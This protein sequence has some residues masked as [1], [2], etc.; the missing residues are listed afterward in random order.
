MQDFKKISDYI[1]TKEAEDE[2]VSLETLLT[3]IPAMAPESD[4]DGEEEK[5]KALEKHL[6]S[7]GF[8]SP[9]YFYAPD[10]RVKT[11][12]RPNMLFTLKGKKEE[13][14]WI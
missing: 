8:P 7:L 14:L 5:A 2:A 1:K 3:S 6:V 12:R 9:Q 11:K 13:E 4:G 10:E